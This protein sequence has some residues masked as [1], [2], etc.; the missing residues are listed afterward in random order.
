M[1]QEENNTQNRKKTPLTN[2]EALTFF[3]IPF[4]FFGLK[5]FK[6]NDFNQSEMDRF[7]Q[8]GF[9]LKVKQANEMTLYGRLFYIALTIIIIYLLKFS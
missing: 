7:K 3:F 2:S 9:D 4:A 1:Q 8:Y 5:K 6:K